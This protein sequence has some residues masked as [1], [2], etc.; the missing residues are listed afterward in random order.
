MLFSTDP[1]YKGKVY[2]PTKKV[3][4]CLAQNYPYKCYVYYYKFYVYL[5]YAS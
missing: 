3:I 5:F 2:K 4:V 1:N